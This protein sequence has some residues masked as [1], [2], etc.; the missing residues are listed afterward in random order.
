MKPLALSALGLLGCTHQ[1]LPATAP[2]PAVARAEITASVFLIGDAGAPSPRGEPVLAALRVLL[3][4]A[5]ESTIVVFLGDNIYP[6]GLPDSAAAGRPDGERR[7]T[8]QLAA[9]RVGSARTI[10]IPGN[11]DWDKS[12]ADGLAA[13]RREGA[14]IRA[15][16][17]GAASL[18]PAAGC[19]GPEVTD[20]AAFRLVLLDTEWWLTH[21]DRPGAEEGCRPATA[22]EVL[23]ALAAAID[24]GA[25]RPVL[26]AGHHPLASGGEHGGHF[27]LL[28]HL[29]PLRA[30]HRAMWL[31]LPI[32]GSLYP[33]IRA[34]GVS[35][36]DLSGG[37]YRRMRL[38][39]DSVFACHPP[40]LYAA[41]HE[42]TLQIIDRGRPPLLLVSGAG[43]VKHEGAVTAVA[44][45]RLALS[46]PGFMRVDQ[47]RDGRLR[48]SVTVVDDAGRGREVHAEWLS[49]PTTR[50]IQRCG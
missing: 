40:L 39:L 11:H 13:V 28:T 26:V 9:T 1:P 17:D 49:N 43:I 4:D 36:E 10:F 7:L 22:E 5:P 23:A 25:G 20:I 34:S 3:R 29:F 47:S 48:L 46:R 50:E 18:L 24:S 30:L 31:P 15:E 6:R 37:R 2:V 41:G 12:G 33:L 8:D 16:S 14:M 45:T 21:H 38:G 42:H 44:G 32:I 19:P 35:D 27:P